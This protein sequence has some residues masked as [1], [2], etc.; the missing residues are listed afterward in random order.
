[1]NQLKPMY[2]GK[3]NGRP[4]PSHVRELLPR[5]S[6]PCPSGN[7]VNAPVC[8]SRRAEGDAPMHRG[9][10]KPKVIPKTSAE[11]A[12]SWRDRQKKMDRGE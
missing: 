12:R 7:G 8:D 10:D 9:Q 3:L 2:W 1:M 11:R 6:L 4:G 5:V